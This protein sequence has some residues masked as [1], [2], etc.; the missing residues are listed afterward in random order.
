MD[1]RRLS[2]WVRAVGGVMPQSTSRI[3]PPPT[4][5]MTASTVMP[6]MSIRRYRP[7]TAPE[8]AKATMPRISKISQV[9]DMGIAS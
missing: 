5:V 3:I 4:P 2:G 6:N 7:T 1:T 8:K 9:M